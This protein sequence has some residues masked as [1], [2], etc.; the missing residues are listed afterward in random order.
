MAVRNFWVD[1]YVDGRSSIHAGPRS[2]D[3]SMRASFKIRNQGS[4]EKSI[5]VVCIPRSDGALSLQV[6]DPD[7]NIVYKHE[8]ER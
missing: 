8:T 2:K 4:A 1:L 5:E 7:A 6:I 3:G